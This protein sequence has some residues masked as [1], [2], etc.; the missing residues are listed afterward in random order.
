[1]RL[2]KFLK[3]CTSVSKY[4]W[5]ETDLGFNVRKPLAIPMWDMEAEDKPKEVK[6]L[7]V[8]PTK[9]LWQR[10]KEWFKRLWKRK[11]Y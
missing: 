4:G 6:P 2:T 11:N 10:I 8:E 7:E 9:S 5:F 1:M 3:K